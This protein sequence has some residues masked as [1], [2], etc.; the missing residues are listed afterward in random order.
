LH[1]QVV[2]NDLEANGYDGC[3][4]AEPVAVTTSCGIEMNVDLWDVVG[5]DT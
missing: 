1:A 5:A 2:Y 4:A 3:H